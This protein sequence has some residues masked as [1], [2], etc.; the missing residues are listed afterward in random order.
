MT[1]LIP[2]TRSCAM[3]TC[4]GIIAALVTGFASAQTAQTITDFTSTPASPVTYAPAPNNTVTLSATGGASG[5]A[6]TFAST[7]PAVCTTGGT[8]GATVTLLT[9]GTCTVTANQA[10]NENYAAAT[11]ATLT[12]TIDKASQAITGFSLPTSLNQAQGST[13]TLSAT[14]GAS[15]NPVVFASSTASVCTTGGTNGSTLT[16]VTVGT[17]TVTVNQAGNDNY[18][19]ATTQT[20]SIAITIPALVFYIHPD[21]LGTPRVITKATDNTKVWEWKNDDPFGNNEANEDPNSTGTSFEFNQRFPGQYR[22]K[23]TGT[24]YNYFRDYDPSLGRYVQS[25]P[26]GL[27]GGI[28]TYG[29]VMGNPLWYF[30]SFGLAK[31]KPT[32]CPKGTDC[33]EPPFDPTKDGPKPS[34][35]PSG[36]KGANPS[37]Y[38][39]DEKEFCEDC[40]SCCTAEMENNARRA[41]GWL[42]NYFWQRPGKALEQSICNSKCAELPRR[43]PVPKPPLGPQAPD[44]NDQAK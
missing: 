37:N 32:I 11:E 38:K 16:V 31:S 30:D 13:L 20:A 1:T 2:L 44:V 19:S 15:G 17:C 18:L 33:I 34:P 5:N 27:L 35:Q 39:C 3:R 12:I 14:G 26:I 21:H 41:G 42:T 29:Y 10:G 6:V 28:N 25:D 40:L 7:T 8:N 43:S 36:K 4:L 22:D 9:A 23:E 24:N